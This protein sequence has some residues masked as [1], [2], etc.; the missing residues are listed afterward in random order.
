MG[1]K[2]TAA[3]I[4]MAPSKPLADWGHSTIAH[5]ASHHS[6]VHQPHANQREN[7][8]RT[9]DGEYDNDDVQYL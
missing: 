3:K 7:C 9:D 4:K 1:M 6:P 5:H 2:K 8:E